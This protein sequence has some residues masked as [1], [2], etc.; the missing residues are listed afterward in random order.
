MHAVPLPSVTNLHTAIVCAL[1][2]DA[3]HNLAQHDDSPPSSISRQ[4]TASSGAGARDHPSSASPVTN[5]SANECYDGSASSVNA[6]SRAPASAHQAVGPS[7]RVREQA[8]SK[9]VHR[10][11]QLQRQSAGAS[12]T[13]QQSAPRLKVPVQLS[14]GL[15]QTQHQKQPRHQLLAQFPQLLQQQQVVSRLSPEEHDQRH[16]EM[17]SKQAAQLFE[18]SAARESIHTPDMAQTCEPHQASGGPASLPESSENPG[19]DLMT[20]D[21]LEARI[22][23]LNK[24]MFTASALRSPHVSAKHAHAA[25]PWGGGPQLRK[26]PQQADAD[27]YKGREVGRAGMPAATAWQKL[28]AQ[29]Q[30]PVMSESSS[31]DCNRSKNSTASECSQDAESQTPDESPQKVSASRQCCARKQDVFL[32]A[33]EH[34]LGNGSPD[35]RVN[36]LLKHDAKIGRQKECIISF[37]QSVDPAHT[38]FGNY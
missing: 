22:A 13:L 20:L 9:V 35:L 21:E 14:E 1:P 29:Q 38:W 34:L 31:D 15:P 24:T 23:G 4:S 5:I 32:S 25:A 28:T 12:G 36:H 37:V 10:L 2:Q 11:S 3:L 16:G 27:G 30:A 17:P 7:Q 18:V 6:S 8:D 19:N 26:Q 33:N